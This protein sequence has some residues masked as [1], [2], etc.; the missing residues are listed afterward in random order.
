M[1]LRSSERSPLLGAQV[2]R[3]ILRALVLTVTAAGVVWTGTTSSRRVCTPV[4]YGWWGGVAP[5]GAPE[6][7][8]AVLHLEPNPLVLA[9]LAVVLVI[10]IA[11]VLRT[12]RTPEES[13]RIL[14]RAVTVIVV[15][16]LVTV[17][18]SQAW[19]RLY[20]YPASGPD[21]AL[22]V[23]PPVPFAWASVVEESFAWLVVQ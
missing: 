14:S 8:C 17:V 2:V 10:S 16:A 15:I 19:L 13:G 11:R 3:D 12:A 7:F 1:S 20:G 9:A 23:I 6:E 22:F 4:P 18:I 21:G 5:S